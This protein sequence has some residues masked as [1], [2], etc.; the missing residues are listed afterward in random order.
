[1]NTVRHRTTSPPLTA[2]Y[3]LFLMRGLI[4]SLDQSEYAV[5]GFCPVCGG[6][7]HRPHCEYQLAK[8]LLGEP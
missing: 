4:R 3:L 2:D 8:R 6:R 5:E 7:D 1:M